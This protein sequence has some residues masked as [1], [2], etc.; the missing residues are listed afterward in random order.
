MQPGKS[1]YFAEKHP[2]QREHSLKHIIE[3]WGGR[4]VSQSDIEVAAVLVG[5]KGD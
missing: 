1:T 5:L 2:T 3:T 4:Y